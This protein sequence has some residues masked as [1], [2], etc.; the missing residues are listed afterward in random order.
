LSKRID[1]RI[2]RSGVR[3][4]YEAFVD[5]ISIGCYPTYQEAEA[6]LDEAAAGEKMREVAA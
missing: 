1:P 4:E 6:A 2:D 5:N 3:I